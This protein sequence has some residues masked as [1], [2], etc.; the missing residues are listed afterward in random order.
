MNMV[1]IAYGILFQR[2][3]MV[4]KGMSNEIEKEIQKENK[5]IE[6]KR[7]SFETEGETDVSDTP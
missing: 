6:K 1:N 4:K 2:P 7:K 5:R 3:D